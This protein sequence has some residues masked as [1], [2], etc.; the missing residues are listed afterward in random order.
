MV[1]AV[2]AAFSRTQ[3]LFRKIAGEKYICG[4]SDEA[5]FF[6]VF[7]MVSKSL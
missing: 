7:V 2:S 5:G 4:F 6:E 1:R 3:P